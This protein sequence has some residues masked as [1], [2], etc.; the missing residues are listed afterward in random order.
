MPEADIQR[1]GPMGSGDRFLANLAY[2]VPGYRGYK[3]KDLRR[4]ED[5]RLR[6]RVMARLGDIQTLLT[7]RLDVLQ[8]VNLE[9]AAIQLAAR[10]TR[11]ENLLSAVRFAPYGFVGFFDVPVIGE[12]KLEQ[13]LEIDLLLFQDLD[14]TVELIRG[15]PFPPANRTAFVRFFGDVDSGI[16]RIE[17]RLVSRDKLLGTC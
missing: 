6:S 2:L 10:I 9:A 16:E 12:D 7:K 5:A 3:E 17:M 11:L 14:E 13:I 1:Q 8:E 4:Q 15:T